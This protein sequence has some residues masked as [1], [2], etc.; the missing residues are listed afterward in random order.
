MEVLLKNQPEGVQLSVKEVGIKLYF[1]TQIS[2][3]MIRYIGQK[4]Y[5]YDV[6]LQVF[7]CENYQ[8]CLILL[9]EQEKC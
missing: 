9:E 3:L 1:L 6:R 7:T 4:Q 8:L 5:V 2:Q